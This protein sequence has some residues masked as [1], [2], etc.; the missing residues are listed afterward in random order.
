MALQLVAILQPNAIPFDSEELYNAAHA[1]L[2]QLEHGSQWLNLQYRGYCGGCTVNAG[3]GAIF[4]TVFGESLF[5]WKLVPIM[6]IGAMTFFGAKA[7]Q[8]TVGPFAILP[9][10]A[11]VCFAP[12]TF[13]ELSLTAWGNHFESGVAA[14]VVL[15]CTLNCRRTPHLIHAVLVGL[16][17]AFALWVGLSSAFLVAGVVVSL[18]HCMTRKLFGF[19]LLGLM[20]VFGVWVYQI[21]TAPSPPFETIYYAGEYMPRLARIPEKLASLLAPRQ[22]VALFGIGGSH[23]GWI[24]GWTSAL[25]LAIGILKSRT[26]P[27]IQPALWFLAAFLVVYSLVRFTVWAPPAPEVA[28]PGSMRYAAPIYGLLFFL[29]SASVALFWK[30][31]RRAIAIALLCPPLAVG[32]QARAVQLQPPFPDFSVF[33]MAAPDFEYARD[34]ISYLLPLEEHR[35]GQTNDAKV[36]ALYDFSIGWHET[37][38]ILDRDPSAV[39]P[40]PTRTSIAAWEGVAAALLPEIDRNRKGGIRTLIFL[41]QRIQHFPERAQ[42]YMHAEVTSRRDW[43]DALP[44]HNDTRVTQ[45]ATKIQPLPP[46]AQRG[47]MMAFG[48]KW[49]EDIA[50]WRDPHPIR[51]PSVSTLPVDHQQA[52]MEGFGLVIGERWG[53][54]SAT[55]DDSIPTSL[56]NAWNTGRKRGLGKRWLTQTH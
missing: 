27:V 30:E 49:A 56:T 12:P 4:F 11:L 9:W 54:G 5:A 40:I 55:M 6:F 23:A 13:L 46:I 34:Q 22:L 17:L 8:G 29:L 41:Q 53:P 3:L 25:C 52:F 20:P 38:R 14:I 37:R 24:L 26:V 31:N 50:R 35:D 43:E 28:P 47:A 19:L 2:I 18:W 16:S 33:D 42:L 32:L 10:A 45:W 44:E 48:T 7:L 15:A 36:V 39:A 1:R 21:L 51:V